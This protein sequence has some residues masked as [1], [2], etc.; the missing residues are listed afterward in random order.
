VQRTFGNGT[1]PVATA[2]QRNFGNAGSTSNGGL[3]PV[4]A[5]SP[6]PHHTSAPV[7]DHAAS[8]TYRYQGRA[9]APFRAPHF[10]W[11]RNEHYVR[12]DVGRHLPRR[13]LA[14]EFLIANWML[15]GLAPPPAGYHWL[16]YGP[17]IVEASDDT[18]EVSDVA[19]DAF[20]ESADED[21]QPPADDDDSSSQ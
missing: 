2:S 21:D 8:A 3:R 1:A 12:Y 15:Y 4:A 19:Y 11:A 13:F 14:T 6:L 20:V 5:A 18:G 17:D 9:Y 7:R 16:R 10:P